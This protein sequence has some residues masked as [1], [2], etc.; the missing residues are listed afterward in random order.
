MKGLLF[1]LVGAVL[2]ASVIVSGALAAPSSHGTVK[3]SIIH[4]QKG[5][6]TWSTSKMQP[7]TLSLT[8]HRR[9]RIHVTN[10]DT[11]GQRL[12][13]VAGPR[14]RFAGALKIGQGTNIGFPKAGVYRFKALAFEVPGMPEVKTTGPD[15]DLVLIVRVP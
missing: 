4:L 15:H 14:L 2:G 12:V 3:V 11:S 7:P 8:L 1:L 5:C 10:A 6:H 13:Q 9:D